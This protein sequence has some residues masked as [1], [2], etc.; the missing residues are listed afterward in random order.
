MNALLFL[1][2]V[3]PYICLTVLVCG[4]LLRYVYAGDTWNARS[5]EIFERQTLRLGS[6]IFHVGILL[7]FGGHI[8][9]LVLPVAALQAIGLNM[10]LHAELATMMGKLLAPLVIIGLGILLFRRLSNAHVWATTTTTDIVIVLL[11]LLN[12][13]TGFYQSYVA[14]FPVFSTVGPWLRSMLT[15]YPAPVYMMTVPLFMKIHV[16]SGL[17]IFALLPFSRLVHIFSAPISYLTFPMTL[18]RK[19]YNNL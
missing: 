18:Y 9:G 15:V 12:A 10:Q 17:T 5:S 6:M 14:H 4:L 11:I 7:S 2:V 19:R 8:I 16:V 1:F 3:Y 13:S